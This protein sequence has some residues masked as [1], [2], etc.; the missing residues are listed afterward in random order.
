[1]RNPTIPLVLI[2]TAILSHTADADDSS[3][4]YANRISVSARAAF[5]ITARFK[6]TQAPA[7]PVARKTPNGDTYN[8]ANGY[9]LTDRSGNAGG[10][11]W[12]WGYDDPGQISGDTILMSRSSLVPGDSAW[13]GTADAG[14]NFGGELAFNR[15]L[16]IRGENRYGI[17][18]AIGYLN[19][20]L[21]DTSPYSEDLRRVTD[22]YPFTPGTTPPLTPPAYQGS[23]QGPGF[24]LGATPANSSA[25]VLPGGALVT[26]S[27]K[28][29]GSLW[30][31]RIG[32]YLEFPLLPWLQASLSGGFSL[33]LL[34]SRASWNEQVSSTGGGS[35]TSSGS[36]DDFALLYGGY[37]GG[38]L[39]VEI[40]PRWSAA[41]LVQYQNLGTYSHQFGGRTVEAD[42]SRSI[43]VGLGV[44][45]RF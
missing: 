14:E 22:A 36:G 26:G 31:I 8:Y 43:F 40:T 19:I 30:G 29:E 38:Q 42:F 6:P 9:V 18:A 34:D 1:M 45:H 23:F 33:G 2:L 37:L 20:S 11:T 4:N 12:Y 35:A 15:E 5:N 13:A 17:E 32:P 10:Q 41:A 3:T 25:S 39:L 44:S 7:A 21:T 28:F 24:L 16:F 27:R